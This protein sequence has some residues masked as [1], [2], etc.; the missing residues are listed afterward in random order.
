M[1]TSL[2]GPNGNKQFYLIQGFIAVSRLAFHDLNHD[3]HDV[4]KAVLGF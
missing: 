4:G 1:S 3:G 2:N